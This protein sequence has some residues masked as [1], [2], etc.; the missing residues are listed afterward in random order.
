MRVLIQLLLLALILLTTA[1]SSTSLPPTST[2]TQ[3]P[4][5][6]PNPSPT[7]IPQ[8]TA[9]L[10]PTPLP[11]A[12]FTLI[13]PTPTWTLVPPTPTA[14]PSPV[15]PTPQTVRL[16]LTE[17]EL[18]EGYK[19]WIESVGLSI[20]EVKVI[21]TDGKIEV[22]MMNVGIPIYMI[23]AFKMVGTYTILDHQLKFQLEEVEPEA[24]WVWIITPTADDVMAGMTENI[25]V[26]EVEIADGKMIIT[27]LTTGS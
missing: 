11:T 6:T 8:P 12:T 4:T 15:A 21:L 1:C 13:P 16:E 18:A 9:S 5:A 27:G 20:E 19:T 10:T 2:P 17:A 3:E 25:D 26:T 24:P 23:E 14:T 22:L 7:W